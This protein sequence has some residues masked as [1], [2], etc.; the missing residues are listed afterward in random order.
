MIQIV[1]KKEGH[2][3]GLLLQFD[4]LDKVAVINDIVDKRMTSFC[5]GDQIKQINYTRVSS[6]QKISAIN[7]VGSIEMGND[8]LFKVKRPKKQEHG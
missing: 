6:I 5:V 7:V 4:E 1:Q 3:L 8:I 2:S